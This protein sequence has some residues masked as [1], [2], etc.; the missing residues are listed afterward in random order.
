MGA[1]IGSPFWAEASQQVGRYPTPA[2]SATACT[3]IPVFGFSY[4][5]PFGWVDRTR[6]MQDD[7]ADASKSLLLLA[8]LKASGGAGETIN[9][10]VVIAAERP[11]AYSGMKTAADEF[12]Q[13]GTHHSQ[14]FPGKRPAHDFHSG[15]AIWCA[16][17]SANRAAPSP[18]ARA[19]WSC[20]KRVTVSFTFIGGSEDEISELI[21]KLSSERGSPAL[22]CVNRNLH[23]PRAT[24]FLQPDIYR[25]DHACHRDPKSENGIQSD[26]LPGNWVL[27]RGRRPRPDYGEGWHP[28]PS[29]PA[30]LRVEMRNV[31]Y[32]FTNQISVHIFRLQGSLLPQEGNSLPIFDDPQSFLLAVD[33]A[34]VSMPGRF[35]QVLNQYV[36]AATDA[37]IKNIA[38]TIQG[39]L[40]KVRGKLYSKGDIPFEA[41]GT[42]AATAD[43]QIRLQAQKIKAAKLPVP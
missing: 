9:S 21:E 40:L 20:W 2:P 34:A 15:P 31:L 16:A 24:P 41:E 26:W 18:C 13:I 12:G 43:G 11:S 10:A 22:P 4:K 30:R 32:H 1:A 5:L 35:L 6:Q 7:S 29:P 25:P 37:P 23:L 39:R 3:T 27:D 28:S 42:L 38:V 8:I 17:I 14:R 19:P 36:F 33:S